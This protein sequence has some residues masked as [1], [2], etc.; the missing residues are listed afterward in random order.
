MSVYLSE[1]GVVMAM[2]ATLIETE[3]TTLKEILRNH[4][5]HTMEARR[6]ELRMIEVETARAKWKTLL[7]GCE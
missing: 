4:Q 3:E 5:Y 2:L 6:F 1:R 7:R